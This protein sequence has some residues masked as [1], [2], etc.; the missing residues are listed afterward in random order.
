MFDRKHYVPILKGR[1]GEY[2]ALES[3]NLDLRDSLT[4]LIEIPPIPWDWAEE[5]P[6]KS[7]DDHLAKV[8]INFEKSIGTE[9]PFFVDLLWI[10][11]SERMEDGSLPLEYVFGT[12]RDLGIFPVPVINLVRSDDF[13][14]AVREIIREDQRG[15]CLRIQRE[16]FTEFDDLENVMLETLRTVSAT[17][18]DTDLILDLRSILAPRQIA[19]EELIELIQ[20]TPR[21]S[22]WRSFTVSA[23]AFPENLSGLP[24]S[25]STP[26]ERTEWLLYRA[27]RRRRRELDRMP[28]FG[29]YA[30]S[31]PEAAEVDP[32]IMRPSAS[33]RYT[34]EESWLVLKGRNLRDNGFGQFYQ[35]CRD[36]IVRPEYSGRSFSWGDGY[37]Y[38]C[39]A[40][41]CGPGNLTTWRKVGTSHHLVFAVRQIATLY[42]S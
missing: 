33:I 14:S 30:I 1:M 40:Q 8:G 35:V 5:Q 4:P 31:H 38:E 21:L 17:P 6:A 24:P 10:P 36:L 15:V 34:R 7:V 29:D 39:A 37:I 12:A 13:L 2:G 19:I 42:G 27:L 22:A 11:D 9:K 3:L 20:S 18:E 25:E 23:T 41:R 16:D 26:I 32:R 28:T